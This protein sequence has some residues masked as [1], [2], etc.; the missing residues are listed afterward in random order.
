MLGQGSCILA[1]QRCCQSHRTTVRTPKRNYIQNILRLCKR[2]QTHQ[3]RFQPLYWVGPTEQQSGY[4][5][6]EFE[7]P[8][9]WTPTCTPQI[10][11]VNFLGLAPEMFYASTSIKKTSI[12]KRYSRNF[13]WHIS[14]P[15]HPFL[16]RALFLK[17]LFWSEAHFFLLTMYLR[18]HSTSVHTAT[19]F[20]LSF[21]DATQSV[22]LV[23]ENM[24]E[25][26]Q[27]NAN[28]LCL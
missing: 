24:T 8:T 13:Y 26:L 6:K 11:A 19:S 4:R 10:S 23:W 28:Q 20:F 15:G 5:T 12:S 18:H 25:S 27:Q 21:S 2:A 9:P 17:T 16:E 22:F 3:N 7:C 1:Q 14:V